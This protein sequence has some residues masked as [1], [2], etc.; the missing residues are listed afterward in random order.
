M[1]DQPQG[2]QEDQSIAQRLSGI[3]GS[4]EESETEELT[5]GSQ[6]EGEENQEP[7]ANG[8]NEENVE[9]ERESEDVTEEEALANAK[10]PERT[11]KYIE[12]LKA[13]AH[14]EAQEPQEP[15]GPQ[16]PQN[17]QPPQTVFD[18]LRGGYQQVGSQQVQQIA[19]PN[20]YE[21]LGQQDVNSILQQQITQDENGNPIVNL[22]GLAKAL[23]QA[24]EQSVRQA[25]ERAG[26]IA[27]QHVEKLEES[28]QNQE[29]IAEFPELNPQSQNF[30][31]GFNDILTAQILK[32]MYEGNQLRA[33]E[34]AREL[35]K[36]RGRPKAAEAEAEQKKEATS[37]EEAPQPVPRGPRRGKVSVADLRRGQWGGGSQGD[38]ATM[39]RM[40]KA[41]LL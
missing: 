36:F 37:K 17:S 32:G 2:E 25:E 19:N 24:Q 7:Q 12:K 40:K 15:Q 9:D 23:Q 16:E 28:Q 21:N 38:Y 27:R 34:Y 14:K 5:P 6:P 26:Q 1:A 29:L 3:Q 4:D 11:K 31:K 18:N 10:N 39:E 13:Q 30:D 8:E 20:Q 33:V 35:A 22:D 41:G